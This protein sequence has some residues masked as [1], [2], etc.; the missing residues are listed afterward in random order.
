MLTANTPVSKLEHLAARL[1]QDIRQRGLCAGDRYLTAPEAANLLGVSAGMA[2]RA[3]RM[4]AQGQ[5]LV[6][7]RNCGT[8]IGPHFEMKRSTATRTVHVVMPSPGIERDVFPLEPFIYGVRSRLHANVLVSF[9]PRGDCQGYVREMVQK[10][11]ATG[12]VAGFVPVSCPHDVYRQLAN[13]GM[14]TV[15]VGTPYVDQSDIVSVDVDNHEAG[16]LLA[17]YLFARGHRRIALI[18]A[19][20]G[21]PGDNDFYDGVSEAMTAAGLPHNA[22][23]VRTVPTQP[24]ALTAQLSRLLIKPDIPTGLIVRTTGMAR[25]VSRAFSSLEVKADNRCEIVYQRYQPIEAVELP[26]AC[27]QAR[28]SFDIIVG[29]IAD[30]LEQL[31]R[32]NV[33]DEPRVVIPVELC[34]RSSP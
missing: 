20:E 26:F 14:P 13:S 23:I 15:I 6:R 27:V 5:M 7:R 25:A 17:E 19:M 33:L 16:R 18:G 31:G 29:R 30:T 22:L 12:I 21:R 32:G 3:M 1:E 10:A 8:F 9:L 11:P 24:T 28:V 4:L 2:H 34:P